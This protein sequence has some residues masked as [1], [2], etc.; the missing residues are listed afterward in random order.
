[1]LLLGI[2]Y[3]RFQQIFPRCIVQ[4]KKQFSEIKHIWTEIYKQFSFLHVI[5]AWILV[6]GSNV[7]S[8]W[9]KSSNPFQIPQESFNISYEEYSERQ[10]TKLLCLLNEKKKALQSIVSCFV[11]SNES[12]RHIVLAAWEF[13]CKLCNMHASANSQLWK[14]MLLFLLFFSKILPL[15][16]RILLYRFLLL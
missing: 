2:L 5:I 7:S 16:S 8:F 11:W 4:R 6:L 3:Q 1:M 14:W 10:L 12:K 15:F 13:A 9:W